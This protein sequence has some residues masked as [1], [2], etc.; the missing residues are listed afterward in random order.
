MPEVACS[1]LGTE[2]WQMLF[3]S[4]VTP[5]PPWQKPIR[6]AMS[7]IPGTPQSPPGVARCRAA[8]VTAVTGGADARS[9]GTA[10]GAAS[11]PEGRGAAWTEERATKERATREDGASRAPRQASQEVQRAGGARRR[12]D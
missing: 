11:E 1:G 8:V 4:P 7:P 12:L 5:P 3:R 2:G 10:A 6:L 9:A